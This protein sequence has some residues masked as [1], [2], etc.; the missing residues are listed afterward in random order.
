MPRL[1]LQ[2]ALH[3]QDKKKAK[4]KPPI[5]HQRFDSTTSQVDSTDE[6][7]L[8]IL[9]QPSKK[10][11]SAK[12]TS[13][14]ASGQSLSVS[15]IVLGTFFSG[16]ETAS[17]ALHQAGIP[18][19]LKY[20]VEAND[21]LREFIKKAFRPEEDHAD[22][23]KVDFRQLPAADLLVG[24]PPCQ[25]FSPAGK[26]QGL[27]DDRGPLIFKMV[28]CVEAR[29]AASLPLPKAVV[30]EEAKTI[31]T[32]A[33]RGVYED[34]KARFKRLGFAV[35]SKCM[36]TSKHGIKQ[37]RHRAYVVAFK[38]VKGRTFSF[39]KDLNGCVPMKYMLK[40]RNKKV[41]TMGCNSKLNQTNIAQAARGGIFDLKFCF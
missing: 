18:S 14:R 32:K 38:K 40:R 39:P 9:P 6:G 30:M 25:S 11:T 15:V 10:T 21:S 16:L 4:E 7:D 2:R 33:H 1:E 5:C 23:T 17:I 28:E 8:I 35:K 29:Q 26:S 36:I 13:S 22:I 37:N 12:A 31:L 34:I 19:V 41:K 24:G 3:C 20:V 27:Q